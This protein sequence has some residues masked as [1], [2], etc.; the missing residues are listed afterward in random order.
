MSRPTAPANAAGLPKLSLEAIGQ[1]IR[2]ADADRER[3][4]LAARRRGRPR[5][6]LRRS[7]TTTPH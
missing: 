3:Y 5:N 7:I 1:M 6:G 4:H 2:T